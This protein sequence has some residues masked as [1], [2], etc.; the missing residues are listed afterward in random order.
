MSVE[1]CGSCETPIYWL[2]HERTGKP[3]PI[4]AE[5][6]PTGNID[7][8]LEAKT[9]RVIPRAMLAVGHG[10]AHLNHFA[11]CPDA[12]GFRSAR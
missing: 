6:S 11:S 7:I 1:H 3:A 10:P 8:D 2:N 5:P 9:Y 4:E 12:D